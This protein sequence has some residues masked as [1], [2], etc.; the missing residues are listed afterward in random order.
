VKTLSKG[1]AIY[2]GASYAVAAGVV[3]ASLP[4]LFAAAANQTYLLQLVA[5]TAVGATLSIFRVFSAGDH[6]NYDLA[7]ALY[8]LALIFL[9]VPAAIVVICASNLATMLSKRYPWPWY[10]HVFNISSFVIAAGVAGLLRSG[11]TVL[12]GY[13]PL[14]A[15][16]AVASAIVAFTLINHL[17]VAGVLW[18]TERITP[19]KSGLFSMTSLLADA[20]LLSNGAICA[21]LAPI[22][23]YAILLGAAP[24]LLI[25]SALRIPRLEHLAKTDGKTGLLQSRHFQHLAEREFE[26]AS[27]LNRPLTLAMLDLD[28]LRDINNTHGHLAGDAAIRAVAATLRAHA[29][30]D[31]VIA[32]FGGEEFALLMVEHQ[33]PAAQTRADALREAIAS[34]LPLLDNNQPLRVTV[35]I[36]LAERN[37]MDLNLAA[38]IARADKALYQ[39]KSA[40]RNCV[41]AARA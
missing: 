27:R 30:P 23:P 10:V 25:H 4:A 38:L 8:G 31:D 15:F 37:E 24:L 3:A 5:L 17:H 39:A 11:L 26:R 41:Y 32:R 33:L 34:A 40:G 35:S 20:S 21:T 36:G 13:A 6:D 28:M 16:V 2:I 7:W 18:F 14:V 9:G 12:P 1:A 22:N 19:R 29:T